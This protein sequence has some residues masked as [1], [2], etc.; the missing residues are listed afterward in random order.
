MGLLVDLWRIHL[1]LDFMESAGFSNLG[2]RIGVRNNSKC[3]NGGSS[4]V[5]RRR[6]LY[7]QICRQLLVV[8]RV[9]A[10]GGMDVLVAIF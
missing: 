4:S 8:G 5:Y 2:D 3:H 10:V 6:R 1:I 7:P 9:V